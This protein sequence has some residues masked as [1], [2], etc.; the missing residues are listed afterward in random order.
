M[1]REIDHGERQIDWDAWFGHPEAADYLTSEG[2]QTMRRAVADLTTFFGPTWLD[3]AIRPDLT[4]HGP[5]IRGL[6]VSAPVFAA[7]PERRAG[8]Y[9]ESIR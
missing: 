6:G 7:T 5:R 1:W 9:V 3:E 4:P 2:K 8:A